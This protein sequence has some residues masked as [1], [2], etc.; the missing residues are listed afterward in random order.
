MTN[1][2]TQFKNSKN[3]VKSNAKT[4]IKNVQTMLE[5][6][7]ALF[8]E[9]K[10]TQV[11]KLNE[12]MSVIIGVNYLP[13]R[14][15]TQYLEDLT[16]FDYVTR[17]KDGKKYRTFAKSDRDAN[18]NLL[19]TQWNEYQRATEEESEIDIDKMITSLEKRLAKVKAD[20]VAKFELKA[21]KKKLVHINKMVADLAQ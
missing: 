20:K 5:L 8:I 14:Q 9:S 21:I 1:L 18:P 13:T 3:R 16:G 10:Q 19:A 2:N 4:A 15:L 17:S 11:V 7:H 12:C 6:G